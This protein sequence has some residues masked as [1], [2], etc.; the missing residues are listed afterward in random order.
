M[1]VDT[2]R[3]WVPPAM[4]DA[5]DRLA[6]ENPTAAMLQGASRAFPGMLDLAGV[7]RI[8][9]GSDYPFRGPVARAVADIQDGPMPEG[10]AALVL[11]DNVQRLW[12]RI[13]ATV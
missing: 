9:L 5:I 6:A 10:G 13:G 11:G 7:D 2:H 1:I 4:A 12:A 3:H 8:L